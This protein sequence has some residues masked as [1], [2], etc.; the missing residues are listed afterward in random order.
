MLPYQQEYIDNINKISELNKCYQSDDV[1]F[2][3][4]CSKIKENKKIVEKIVQRN[5][6]ILKEELFPLLDD[7]FK[8]DKKDIDDIFEFANSLLN[9]REELDVG[10]YSQIHNA[11]LGYM[12]QIRDRNGTIR[13]LYHMGIGYYNIYQKTV[14]LEPKDN[15]RYNTQMRLY[16]T[17]AAAYLKYYDE[18]ED[19]E[20]KGFILRS[21]ANMALG[22][23]KSVTEKNAMVKRSLMILQDKEYQRKAPSLPWDKFIYLSHRQMTA[24]IS[25]GDENS[26][27]PE[28]VADIM[29]SAHIVYDKRKK[30]ADEKKESVPIQTQFNHYAI[31]YYCGIH[32]L[33][34]LLTEI[35]RIMDSVDIND[36]S[37]NGVYGM[38][39]LTAFYYQYLN[40]NPQLI[41]SRLEYLEELNKR[42]WDYVAAFPE[43]AHNENLFISL[44]KLSYTYIE[45]KNGISYKQFI[46]KALMC[47]APEVYSHSYAVGMAAGELCKLLVTD[48]PVFFDDIEEIRKIVNYEE[49]CKKIQ[50]FAMECGLMHDI[51]KLSLFS[52]YSN[53]SRQWLREEF[54]LAN[55]H[56][57]AG[58]VCLEK[59]ESTKK[60]ADVALGHHRWYD[61][62]E[63]YPEDYK[64]LDSPYRQMI[65]VIAVIDWIDNVTDA[66]RLYNGIA[67]T[68]DEAVQNVIEYEGKRF[69]P[70]LTARF[71]EKNIADH[72]RESLEKGRREAYRS[73][74]DEI[75]KSSHKKNPQ[76][77]KK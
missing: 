34:E 36:Y 75:K 76:E 8:A 35:E 10:L 18:I 26:M 20:T 30:E 62:V 38:I 43:P 45:T 1:S 69:S 3:E 53:T 46:L 42:I 72:I 73:M 2:D 37:P 5:M 64:R 16:F 58:K 31:E 32:T 12:R 41:S 14:I 70:L 67:K 19:D 59:R 71:R 44:S 33:D 39:A 13:E 65:D 66:S 11:L 25:Y 52:L 51:G 47:F 74:F 23:F 60:F 55:L 57:T 6:R 40:K 50:T 54:E 4:Y 49:K 21:R 28:D 56:T 48:D 22:R 24:N 77:A 27:S 9:T 63:G 29:E 7:M 15:E 17:E 61:G 68:Y